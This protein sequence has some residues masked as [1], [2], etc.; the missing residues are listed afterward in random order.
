MI[1]EPVDTILRFRVVLRLHTKLKGGDIRIQTYASVLGGAVVSTVD[2][3]QL[4]SAVSEA[5]RGPLCVE[6]IFSI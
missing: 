2:S 4:K 3:Q 6:F 1:Q 5:E